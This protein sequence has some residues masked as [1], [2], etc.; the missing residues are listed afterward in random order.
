[1]KK[2]IVLVAMAFGLV[3][4]WMESARAQAEAPA[5]ESKPEELDVEA[6]KKKYWATGDESQLGVVQ[7]R[8][9]SKGGKFALGVLGGLALSDPFNT[10][11]PLGATFGYN[12]SELWGLHLVA[13]KHNST[14]SGA[15][16]VLRA[17]GKDFSY[18]L[19]QHYYGLEGTASLLYGKLSFLGAKIVYYDLHLSAA[20]GNTKTE[21][22]NA[23]TLGGGLGQRFYVTQSLSIRVDYRFQH[24]REV[25][26]EKVVPTALG[27]IIGTR[28]NFTHNVHFG[29]DFLFGGGQ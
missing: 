8:L 19:A 6:I 20:A 21:W 25:Q 24:Y 17:T 1:M 28:S 14:T 23:M 13:W 12:F 15:Y 9:Y 26:K 22:E 5:G 18:V 10:I 2:R 16:D 11:R 7:N 27:E 4:P 29:L 3:A